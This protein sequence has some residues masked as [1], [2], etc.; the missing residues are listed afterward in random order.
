[1]TL[2]E[3]D[4]SKCKR[5]GVCA[6]ECPAGIIQLKD[7][8]SFPEVVPGGEEA[9]LVCGHCVAACPH[10][11]LSHAQIPAQ[12]CPPVRKDLV[13]GPEQAVQFLRSRRSIRQYRDAPVEKEKVQKLI[14]IARYAPTG[15]NTQLLEWWVFT[16]RN[17]L[18]RFAEMAVDWIRDLLRKASPAIFPPYFARILAGWEAG[19]D[20]ILRKAPVLILASAPAETPNGMVEIA[21][22]LT[23]LQLAA[24]PFGL[25]TCWAGL[26]QRALLH[27]QPLKQAFGLPEKAP[28]H[29]PM[30]LGYPRLEYHRLPKRKPPKIM[31]K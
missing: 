28:H 26:L 19:H 31:W 20:T 17:Q 29:Y 27:S 8:A 2:I 4:V 13:V 22:A 10:G 7:K 9:C 21:A 16:D 6:S 1:M 30:M 15:G 23:Y 5:D 11:A 14:E 18:K 25:G 3:V 12:G 24:L